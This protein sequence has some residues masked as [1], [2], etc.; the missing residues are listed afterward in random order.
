M[1][2]IMAK[3]SATCLIIPKGDRDGAIK[4][5]VRYLKLNRKPDYALVLGEKLISMLP[6][7]DVQSS[8]STIN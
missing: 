2:L 8:K 6:Y 3:A 1:L 7:I 5:A 4:I